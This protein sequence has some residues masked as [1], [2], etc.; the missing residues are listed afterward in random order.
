MPGTF[1]SLAGIGVYFLVRN[2]VWAYIWTTIIVVI[3]GFL[4]SGG[5]EKITGKKDDQRIVIDEVAGML[6]SLLFIPFDLRLVV[7]GFIIFRLLDTIKPFAI[8]HLQKLKASS[9][10]MLDDIAA[11]LCTNI[12]LQL[13]LSLTSFKAS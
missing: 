2:N 7:A 13:F 6:L 12:I 8:R 9:G 4:V 5:F 11:A 10:V 3:L 1:G